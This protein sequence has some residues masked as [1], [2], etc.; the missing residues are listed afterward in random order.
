MF[1]QR[2]ERRPNVYVAMR[3][4]LPGVT[5]KSMALLFLGTL[6]EHPVFSSQSGFCGHAEERGGL[7]DYNRSRPDRRCAKRKGYVY[8]P[9]AF[10]DGVVGR[11]LG[12]IAKQPGKKPCSS[13]L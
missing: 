8:M 1:F 6:A 2:P 10:W 4:L 12:C 5:V 13:L 9:W 11:G 7:C 3:D